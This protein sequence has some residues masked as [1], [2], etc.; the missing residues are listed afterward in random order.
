MRIWNISARGL[1]AAAGL[2]AFALLSGCGNAPTSPTPSNPGSFKGQMRSELE[3]SRREFVVE[4]RERLDEIDNRIAQLDSRLANESELV[5]ESQKAEWQQ[6]LF[7][8]RQERDV[9]RA[10]L[11]RAEAT[12]PDEFRQ[13]R[14]TIGLQLDR[15]EAGIDALVNSITGVFRGDEEQTE[16][17]RGEDDWETRGPGWE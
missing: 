1:G 15:V 13:M 4:T 14:G 16:P 3:E 9:A 17:V 2:A 10:E 11:A 6:E 5:S 8:L 12:S 7:E